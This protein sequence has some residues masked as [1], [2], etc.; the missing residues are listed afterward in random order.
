[1]TPKQR[2]LSNFTKSYLIEIAI[3]VE[4]IGASQMKKGE[5]VSAFSRKRLVRIDKI[6]SEF[7]LKA[8]GVEQR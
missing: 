6:L 8:L 5:L 1:M 4:I 3:A 7:S 2:I